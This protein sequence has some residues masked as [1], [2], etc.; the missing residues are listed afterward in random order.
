MT[1]HCDRE[2]WRA[3]DRVTPYGIQRSTSCNPLIL[4]NVWRQCGERS[5]PMIIRCNQRLTRRHREARFY[6]GSH[7]EFNMYPLDTQELNADR[8]EHFSSSVHRFQAN[9][10]YSTCVPQ[11]SMSNHN[12]FASNPTDHPHRKQRL[13]TQD[14]FG[15][16]F[17]SKA[18][19][20]QW[21]SRA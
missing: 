17:H 3:S 8:V 9:S 16:N 20:D 15:N 2:Q 10:L 1:P 12:E 7:W 11:Q 6:Q 21:T 4:V 5:M 18:C 13:S 19:R 14:V